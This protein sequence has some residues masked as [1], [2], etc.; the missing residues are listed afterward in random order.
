MLNSTIV[1]FFILDQI[2]TGKLGPACLVIFGSV[3]CS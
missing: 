1:V 3:L 2:T